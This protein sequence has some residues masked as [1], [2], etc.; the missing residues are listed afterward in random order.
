[1]PQVQRRVSLNRLST[2][3]VG[4]VAETLVRPRTSGE[5]ASFLSRSCSISSRPH[6]L[7]RGSNTLIADGLI[8]RPVIL[9]SR[10]DASVR[11]DSITGVIRAGSGAPLPSIASCAAAAGIAGL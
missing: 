8:T 1:M 5:L 9:M 4:G 6:V 3:R 7:G 2:L 11:V 10:F